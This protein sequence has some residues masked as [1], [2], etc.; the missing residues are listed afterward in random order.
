MGG[1]FNFLFDLFSKRRFVFILLNLAILALA[2]YFA[3]KLKLEEDITKS[4]PGSKEYINL[5]IKQSKLTNK[6]ILNIYL[7][8]TLAEVDPDQLITYANE[9]ADSLKNKNFSPFISRMTFR[10]D[11]GAMDEIMNSIRNH[12]PIFLDEDDYTKIDTLIS[13]VNIKKSLEKNYRTL[14]SPS[15]FA[16]KKFI[17]EDPIGLSAVAYNKMKQFQVDE[18]YTVYN[19]FIFTKDKR[20]LMC[21]IDPVFLS[22]ETSKNTAFINILDQLINQLSEKNKHKIATEY[23]GACAVGVGNATQIKKDIIITVSISI[24]IILLFVGWVFRSGSIP[25]ISFLPAVFGGGIAMAFLYLIKSSVSTIA[26]AVG[27]VLL[28]IIVDYALYFFSL[29]KTKGNVRE[30]LND[31][32]IT[33]FLCSFTTAIAFFS[34][35]FVDSEVLHDLGLFAG[36]SI[37]GAAFFSLFILPHLIKQKKPQTITNN[38]KSIID[39]IA[40]YSF[41]KNIFLILCIILIT[42]LSVFTYKKADFEKDMYSMN[43]L[44]VHLKTAEDHLNHIS[45]ISQKSI[46]VVAVG[47]DLNQA[48]K[49]HSKI[50]PLLN[51][52]KNKGL[53]QNFSNPG[54]VVIADSV[55]KSKIKRWNNYWTEKKKND[56][57]TTLNNY[58]KK[59]GFQTNAFPHFISFLNKDFKPISEPES[60]KIKQTFVEDMITQTGNVTMVTTLLKVNLNDREKVFASL[61]NIPDITIIDKLK[62][63]SDFIESIKKDF[64]MLV[65]LCLIF[66]T[67]VLIISFGRIELGLIAAIPMFASWFVTLGIMGLTGIKFNIFNILISTFIFGLGVDYSILMMRGLLLEYQF[68]RKELPSYKTSIFLSAF[69]TIVGVGVLIFAKHPSLNSISILSIIGLSSVVIISYTIEPIFFNYLIRKKNKKRNSPVTFS[70]IIF[71]VLCFTNAI[72]CSVLLNLSLL[73]TILLPLSLQK[74]KMIMHYIMMYIC[75]FIVYSAFP[76]KKKIINKSGEDFSQPAVII[77]NHQSHLDLLL[78]IMLNPKIIIITNKWVWMNPFYGLVIRFLDYFPIMEGYE[79]IMEQLAN[80]VKEGFSILIFP[81]G[82]RTVDAH[83]TRFHKG[84]FMIAEKLHM[85]ILPIIIHGVGDCMNKGENHLKKG[86]ITITIFDRIKPDDSRYGSDYHERTKSTLTFFRTNYA[87]LQKEL[88]TVDY[89]KHQLIR[90]YIYKGPVLEWYLKVKIRLEKN[91][92]LF[93]RII[94]REAEIIDIGCGYGFLPYMLHLVSPKRKI[95]GIDYDEQKIET[96]NHCYLK[97]ENIN[98]AATD[99]LEYSFATYDVCIMNDILHYLTE[100]KQEQ[101]IA[102]CISHLKKDGMIIIRDG[103]K[104]MGKKHFGTEWTEFFSTKFFRFNKTNGNKLHF[105]SA[106]RI[107]EIINKFDM[108]IEI[109]DKTVFTS[110]LIYIIRKKQHAEI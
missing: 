12:L 90:S 41:E 1:F 55:Q 83:I 96:A 33:I 72:L 49:N 63:T 34:L 8:D 25:F 106:S 73:I 48:I 54:A 68:G 47:K 30:V 81:E 14:L 99:A 7:T 86:N 75:K 22:S 94:S 13:P 21:F 42:G 57:Q 40:G 84:A 26:L 61:S 20:H 36:F 4:I 27:S 108:E 64:E 93:N 110:N 28:G 50:I 60:K 101:L 82:S 6:L 89:Y 66:V 92:E 46:Y 31:L 67:L 98:F 9:L 45:K 37:L 103:N 69:T 109:I 23:Y 71:T 11:E 59:I 38:K 87:E 44:P 65:N 51:D 102:K 95:T 62:I 79:S 105:V 78:M 19:G 32:S 16:L 58:S 17:L 10:L 74:K 5:M 3:F 104:D 53:I 56:L 107:S 43:Y 39:R 2:G 70:D 85:D 18:N 15:G 29:Y 35:L 88:G 52:L 91:Y 24:L 100:E 97:D 76:I 77:S 80:K